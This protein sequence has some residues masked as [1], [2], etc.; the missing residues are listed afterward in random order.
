MFFFFN[1]KKELGSWYFFNRPDPDFSRAWDSR[2][3]SLLIFQDRIRASTRPCPRAARPS[4]HP[5]FTSSKLYH[6]R[7]LLWTESLYCAPLY[8]QTINFNLCHGFL[9]NMSIRPRQKSP[10]HCVMA[11][12][13]TR[14][15]GHPVTRFPL[16][17]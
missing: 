17:M 5:T 1:S 2:A 13:L 9:Y 3:W 16:Y 14:Y 11:L 12:V 7:S 4:S 15:N 8:R 10:A 6:K